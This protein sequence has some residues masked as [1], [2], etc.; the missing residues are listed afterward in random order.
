MIDHITLKALVRPFIPGAP[1]QFD[2]VAILRNSIIK[3]VPTT[4]YLNSPVTG[5][6]VEV[7]PSV[8]DVGGTSWQFLTI[9]IPVA[10][11]LAGQNMVHNG[12]EAL[13][14][15]LKCIRALVKWVLRSYQFTQEETAMFLKNTIIQTVEFTWHIVTAS[16]RA[17]LNAQARTI[18]H[19]D[20]LENIKGRHDVL[21]KDVDIW[22][23]NGKT[24]MLVTFKDGSQFRQYIKAEQATSRTKNNRRACFLSKKMR[25]YLP[26]I[27]EAIDTHL[28]NEVI[29]S[30]SFLNERG[31][32]HPR[33]WTAEAIESA[34]VA[35]MDMGRLNQRRVLKSSDLVRDGLSPEVLKTVERY[36]SGEPMADSLSPQVFS[37]HRKLLL[38][39]NIDIADER[40]NSVSRGGMQLQFAKRWIP[41]DELSKLAICD[42]S[43]NA[44][45]EFLTCAPVH[46]NGPY[47][48]DADAVI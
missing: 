6:Q 18:A 19:F 38:P 41:G 9:T 1:S 33:S 26:M 45:F 28:R 7:L 27:L 44:I 48:S 24:C 40:S 10:A 25:P 37:K 31:L 22:C 42:D 17:T 16:R 20:A 11:T 8:E 35:V 4:S 23:R 13:P 39:R 36:F 3:T 46:A 15:E 34:I 2:Q 5:A 32:L 29:L 47:S 43:A 12:L 21:V 14:H 30:A